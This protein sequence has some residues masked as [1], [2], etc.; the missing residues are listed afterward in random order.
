MVL[1]SEHHRYPGSDYYDYSAC[2]PTSPPWTPKWVRETA[3]SMPSMLHVST[4]S[5]QLSTLHHHTAIPIHQ[6]MPNHV[7]H[8]SHLSRPYCSSTAASQL[9][10][11]IIMEFVVRQKESITG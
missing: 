8:S 5:K 6:H 11:W 10:C 9:K 1:V 7:P 3:P 2:K 4:Q